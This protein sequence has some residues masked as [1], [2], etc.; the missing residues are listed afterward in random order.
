MQEL[1]QGIHPFQKIYFRSERE[2]FERLA[3]GQYPL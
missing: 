2:L 1:V 3:Q